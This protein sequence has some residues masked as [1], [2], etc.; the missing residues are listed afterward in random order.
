MEFEGLD[1][2]GHQPGGFVIPSRDVQQLQVWRNSEL[3][4]LGLAL[5]LGRCNLPLGVE[6]LDTVS[7]GQ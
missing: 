2:T 5:L 6:D 1:F 4:M 3:G 7:L